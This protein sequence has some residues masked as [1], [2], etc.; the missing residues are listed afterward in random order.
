[1]RGVFS[2]ND[3]LKKWVSKILH[4]FYISLWLPGVK[5]LT[6]SNPDRQNPE[7]KLYYCN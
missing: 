5:L 2:H 4:P 1:M 6:N 3:I 7:A